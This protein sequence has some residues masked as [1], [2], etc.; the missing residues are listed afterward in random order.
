[1]YK[2]KLLNKFYEALFS[3]DFHGYATSTQNEK[4]DLLIIDPD[5]S[6]EEWY[7]TLIETF[8]NEF[9][10]DLKTVKNAVIRDIDF[11]ND[12]EIEFNYLTSLLS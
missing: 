1:M 9:N 5:I 4:T 11:I 3:T 6:F 10:E 2:N 8:C 12:L 7:N